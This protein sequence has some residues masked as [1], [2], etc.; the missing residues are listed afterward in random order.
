[1]LIRHAVGGIL[2]ATFLNALESW[3][4]AHLP[5][6]IP[7]GQSDPETVRDCRHNAVLWAGEELSRGRFREP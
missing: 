1:M 4:L 2:T 7:V 6:K 3:N 5:L